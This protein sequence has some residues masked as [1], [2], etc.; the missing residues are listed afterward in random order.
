MPRIEVV[1]VVVVV[2]VLVASVVVALGAARLGARIH[3]KR[4]TDID[5][6]HWIDS[7]LCVRRTKRPSEIGRG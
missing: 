3:R 4:T 2:L 7:N 5:W 1:I 6:I